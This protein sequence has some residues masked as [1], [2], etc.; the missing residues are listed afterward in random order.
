[1]PR[2]GLRDIYRQCKPGQVARLPCLFLVQ[3]Q[4]I[5]YKI[6]IERKTPLVDR[7][8]GWSGSVLYI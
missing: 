3:N 7:H 8:A 4:L 2:Y 6:S 5:M 1:M